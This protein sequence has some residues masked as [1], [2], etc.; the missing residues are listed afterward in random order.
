MHFATLVAVEDLSSV[1]MA[2]E[3]F[4]SDADD[5]YLEFYD[6]TNDLKDEYQRSKITAIRLANGKLISSHELKYNQFKIESDLVYEKCKDGT[7]Q[8]TPKACSMTV[9]PNTPATDVYKT[10]RSYATRHALREYNKDYKAYGYF[11]NP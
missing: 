3:P 5:T 10:Y 8:R 4:A 2:M 11:F 1:D 6:E 9:L 7:Y